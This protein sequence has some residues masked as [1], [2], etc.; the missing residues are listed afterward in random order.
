MK[1]PKARRC[2][3]LG[4]FLV[5]PPAFWALVLAIVPTDWARARLVARLEQATHRRVQIRSVRLGP[6]GG[7]KLGDLE[8]GEPAPDQPPWLSVREL[9][10]DINLV[11]LI[12]GSCGLTDVKADGVV[13]RVHRRKDGTFEFGDLLCGSPKAEATTVASDGTAAEEH[14][15]VQFRLGD[16]KLTIIDEPSDTRLEFV[17][18]E[19]KGN[20]QRRK[21]VLEELKGELNGGRFEMVAQLDRSDP[22]GPAFEGQLRATGVGLG[23]GMKALS[24]LLPV[25]AGMPS[26]VDGKLDLDLDLR[27][28]GA[29]TAAVERALVGR[30]A[31]ALEPIRM[32]GSKVV[33]ELADALHLPAGERAGSIRS[34]FEI[35]DGR[36]DSK[37]LTIRLGRIPIP[38]AGWTDFSGRVDY[39]VRPEGLAGKVPAGV[40]GLLADLSLDASDLASMRVRGTV[41]DLAVT[42]EGVPI[43][44][45]GAGDLRQ[46][47]EARARLKEAARRLRQRIVR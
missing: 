39:R 34:D 33:A 10:V 13:L 44:G 15:P 5:A 26:Q 8:I 25:V 30:G 38:L 14:P 46:N 11:S 41:S 9:R 3:W 45:K 20:W 19:A 22:G 43:T 18:V 28:H 7:V 40:Q 31:I 24:Y 23:M 17:G 29:T 1:R 16:L 2:L 4:F 35:R 6:F 42:V 36:I 32:D 27:G 37:D 21:A 47:P 12:S